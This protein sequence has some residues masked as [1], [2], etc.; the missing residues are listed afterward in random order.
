M[1]IGGGKRF[2]DV[3]PKDWESFARKT[4]LVRSRVRRDLLAMA[5]KLPAE[6]HSLAYELKDSTQESMHAMFDRIVEDVEV[7][8]DS[9]G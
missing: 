5:E 7:R 3:S 4:G 1:K 8:A 9:I 6:A 2:G